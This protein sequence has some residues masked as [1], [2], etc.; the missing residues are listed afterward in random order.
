M[1]RKTEII[2]FRVSAAEKRRI[3]KDAKKA[4]IKSYSAYITMLIRMAR[5]GR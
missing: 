2:R 1:E 5:S 4:T 3:K